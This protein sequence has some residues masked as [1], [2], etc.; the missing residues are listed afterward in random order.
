MAD[1]RK[2]LTVPDLRARKAA[3]EK[4]VMVSVPD[5]PMAVW[6]A[7][8]GVDIAEYSGARGAFRL[9]R[10]DYGWDVDDTTGTEGNDK[11]GYSVAGAGDLNG[12]GI[13]DLVI[14]APLHDGA[15]TN[16]GAVYVL[17]GSTAGHVSPVSIEQ[18]ADGDNGFKVVGEDL[19]DWAGSAISGIGVGS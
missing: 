5:F 19:G 8:A 14:G 15:E 9:S 11:F 12:D 2:K 18:I 10:T 3:G 4:V 7:R 16:M 13:A 6:A 1:E 17:F